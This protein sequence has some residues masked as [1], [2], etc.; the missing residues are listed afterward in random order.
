MHTAD[1]NLAIVNNLFP[2][3]KSKNGHKILQKHNPYGASL[4]HPKSIIIHCMAEY[5]ETV[6]GFEYAPDFLM[7]M[8]ISAHAMVCPDGTIIRCRKDDE[9]AYHARDFN[10]DSLGIEILVGGKH[11]YDSF[12]KTIKTPYTTYAQYDALVEQVKDWI[13]CYNIIDIKRHSD[14]SPGRKIDP[15]AGFN[16]DKFLTDIHKKEEA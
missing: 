2:A 6:N 5:V 7:L 13:K 10:T 14:V 1:E 15:G 16:W 9:G 11:G 4:N 8:S 12:A 3:D